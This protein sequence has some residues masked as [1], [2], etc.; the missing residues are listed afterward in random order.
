MKAKMLL[1]S[2]KR[3]NSNHLQHWNVIF[4]RDGFMER[5]GADGPKQ[6]VFSERFLRFLISHTGSNDAGDS[7]N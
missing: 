4:G 2:A 1:G 5:V 6:E 7:S 3:K